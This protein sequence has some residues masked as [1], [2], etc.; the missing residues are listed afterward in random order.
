MI[1][2]RT[3]RWIAALCALVTLAGWAE[4][5]ARAAKRSEP[6]TEC[7]CPARAPKHVDT[8]APRLAAAARCCELTE[9]TF[10]PPSPARLAPAAE[11]PT[12][13]WIAAVAPAVSPARPD[14][15]R[16]AAARERGPPPNAHDHL[17]AKSSLLL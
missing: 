5:T 9:V 4:R 6:L 2:R 3:F 16:V 17:L 11:L 14:G 10:E 12:L 8:D 1:A 7:C 15:V 13:V